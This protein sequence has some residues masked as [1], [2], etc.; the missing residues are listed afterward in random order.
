MIRTPS[1]QPGSFGR[2][3]RHGGTALLAL[4]AG[5]TAPALAQTQPSIALRDSFRVGSAGVLCTAQ[6]RPTDAALTSMFDRGYRVVCRDAASPVASLYALRGGDGDRL[7]QYLQAAMSRLSCGEKQ[8]TEVETVGGA[9]VIECRDPK[10]GVDY[11]IYAAVRGDTVF[12]AEGLSGYDSAL[13]L[14]LATLVTDRAVPGTVDVATTQVSDPAAFARIQAGTL[15]EESARVEAYVRNNY[16]A[17]AES[18]EFFETLA[19][20]EQGGTERT[21]EFLA[22]QALQQSNMGDFAT[23]GALFA[24]ADKLVASSDGV[25]QRMIR[26]FRAIDAINQRNPEEAIKVLNRPVSIDTELIGETRLSQGEITKMLADQIN[27]ENSG[28][29]RLGGVDSSLTGPERA[30]ILDGQALLLRGTALRLSGQSDAALLALQQGIDTIVAVRNGR[31]SSTGWLR[32]EVATQRALIQESRGDFAGARAGLTEALDIYRLDYPQSPGLLSAK[33]R[34]AAFLAR[35]GEADASIALY[36]EIVAEG[37]AVPSARASMKEML[38]PYFA[39]LA[40]RADSDQQV[41][42]RMFNASQLLQRPGVAQTQAVLARELSEGNDEASALFRLAVTR[43]RE[44]SRTSA[45]IQRLEALP[46]P[47][48]DDV[49]T[50]ALARESLTTQQN[51]Q[52]ALQS[53]LGQYSQY[54]VLSPTSVTLP[55]L[56]KLLGPREGYYKVSFVGAKVYGQLITADKVRTVSVNLSRTDLDK[57]VAKLRD[58]IVV[59]ENG[60]PTNYPFDVVEARKLYDALFPGL[61]QDLAGIEHLVYEPDG[62]LLQLPP[63]LLVEDQKGVDAYLE[64]SAALDAD[65]F[66]FTGVA[67]FGRD[68]RFS[69]AVSPRSFADVRTIAPARGKQAYLGVG[70]NAPPPERIQLA[71]ASRDADCEWPVATWMDPISPAELKLAQSV[72]GA[73]RANVLTQQ[74]F[75]DTALLGRDDLNE[76]RIL[77]FATHGLVT[78]PR[79]E[80]PAR[81]ALVTSFGDASSDGLLSFKEIFDLKLDADLVIL[82]ACDTAGLATVSASREAGIETGGNFALDGLVR[83]FVGAGARSVLASHW[84]VPDDFNATENLIS[85]LFKASP[86]T[87]MNESLA[88]AQRTAMDDPLTSHPYYWAAFI[89]LGDGTKPLVK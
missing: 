58:S 88:K 86:G 57:T 64:R 29:K 16:G 32:A 2:A 60:Q 78:A 18:S 89:L 9:S 56:Q 6:Y 73:G 48:P 7:A 69:I 30:Q 87:A 34:L 55:E 81:P 24:R 68:R 4:A 63:G 50:L 21:A 5:I 52:T 70:E 10:A 84:P 27:R 85:S 3:L 37:E 13:K 53:R 17:Y 66:D 39:Q 75:S 11:R 15:D 77:H 54:R 82:S 80:C 41:A 8:V 26:N 33:G 14:A 22:N 79:P 1:L 83:A 25:T 62:A 38:G 74:S 61:Q 23:A 20:R 42:A 46:S 71:S 76:Y 45:E 59:I 44:I 49:A 43:T 35:R 31:I 28:L 65:P 19:A 67:W 12:V 36:D 72:L 47:T 40:V 51:E